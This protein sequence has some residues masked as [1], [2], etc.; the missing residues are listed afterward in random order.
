MDFYQKSCFKESIN[1]RVKKVSM[2]QQTFMENNLFYLS[3]RIKTNRFI[4]ASCTQDRSCSQDTLDKMFSATAT[5]E[6]L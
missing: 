4:E 2:Y 6:D 5:F 3:Y 1:K